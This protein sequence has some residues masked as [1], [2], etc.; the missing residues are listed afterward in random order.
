MTVRFLAELVFPGVPSAVP[1]ARHCVSNVLRAAGHRD[2]TGVQLVVSELVANALMHSVSGLAGGLIIVDVRA[3]GDGIARIDVMD[4]GGLTVPRMRQ[5]SDMDSSGRGF[6]IVEATALR[7]GIG[8]NAL[9]GRAAWAEVLTT[10]DS[11][12]DMSSAPACATV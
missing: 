2:T 4:D 1:A 3:I 12:L 11:T 10:D 7:W 8:D 9:G 6:H 5:P